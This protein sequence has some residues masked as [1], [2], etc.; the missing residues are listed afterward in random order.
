MPITN[1]LVIINGTAIR[2]IPEFKI[3]YEKFESGHYVIGGIIVV[4]LSG[5][6]IGSSID[7][8][9]NKIK[10]ISGYNAKCQTIKISCNDAVLID[11]IGFVRNV[12][13]LSGDQP[14]VVN[15]SMDIAVQRN[16]GLSPIVPDQEFINIYELSIPNILNLMS[17]EESIDVNGDDN[18]ANVASYGGGTVSKAYLKLS[19]SLSMQAYGSSC[20][21]NDNTDLIYQVLKTRVEKII[22]L[23]SAVIKA[24]PV[25][26]NYFGNGWVALNDT[27]SINID[28]LNN[29]IDWKFDIYIVKGNCPQDA[30]IDLN[31]VETTDQNTGLS[32]YNVRGNIRG[33]GTP[34]TSVLDNRVVGADK[35]NK[36]RAALSY[37]LANGSVGGAFY[38]TFLI[39]C[40]NA[41]QKPSTACYQRSSA[42]TTESVNSAQINFDF[43]YE[44]VENC[45]LGGVNIDYSITEEEPT[46]KYVDFI[47]PGRVYPII[48]ISQS[49]SAY[50]ASLTT[51]GRMNTCNI[52]EIGTLKNCVLSSHNNMMLYKGFQNLILV[53][54]ELSQGK[55]S[56]KITDSYIGCI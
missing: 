23:S 41:A 8:L 51:T 10:A 19:A 25:L 12:N 15:Y 11:G 33:L 38:N 47:V 32:A 46:Q 42:Q 27:K 29:K 5:K 16:F 36:A 30:L 40:F 7:D 43:K 13:I 56:F 4:Q 26:S 14:F 22:S 45:Q 3:A 37:I 55:Y 35:L 34:T 9:N 2:P 52:N 39:G 31:I 50:T 20:L 48:Q 24:Y 17:Y 6:I 18:L 1:N 54:R 28:Q 49:P 44:D 53:K 21:G